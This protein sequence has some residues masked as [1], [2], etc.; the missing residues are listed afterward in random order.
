MRLRSALV[1]APLT[2]ALTIGGMS[3]A[4]AAP[5]KAAEGPID[6]T[7]NITVDIVGV[8]GCAVDAVNN[9]TNQ[10]L[11]LNCLTGR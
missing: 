5:E 3:T 8:V 10:T 7:L 6:A 1:L 4:S 11:L 2:L 9:P